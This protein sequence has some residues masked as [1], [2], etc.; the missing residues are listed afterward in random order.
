MTNNSTNV[1]I[2]CRENEGFWMLTIG[3][4]KMIPSMD[5]V[6]GIQNSVCGECCCERPPNRPMAS[7]T[8]LY[9]KVILKLWRGQCQ[10]V[11]GHHAPFENCLVGASTVT[12]RIFR[13][14]L[15]QEYSCCHVQTTA[16][17]T[18]WC[19]SW[20]IYR[21]SRIKSHFVNAKNLTRCLKENKKSASWNAA[22]TPKRNK[23]QSPQSWRLAV[24][25]FAKPDWEEN[26]SL[27]INGNLESMLSWAQDL[28][29][30]AIKP[31]IKVMFLSC[32]IRHCPITMNATKDGRDSRL[33]RF[34]SIMRNCLLVL[35]WCNSAK[36][37]PL[38]GCKQRR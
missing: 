38:H 20:N 9:F 5:S 14:S 27:L 7:I 25:F 17:F 19:V 31:V 22:N 18:H 24:F 33:F 16:L 1:N 34:Q 28:H 13:N 10:T 11:K 32:Y 15:L 36:W 23:N 12:W 35:S 8:N 30:Y 3:L 29:I 6:M 4:V 21:Q 37:N 2:F 26:T